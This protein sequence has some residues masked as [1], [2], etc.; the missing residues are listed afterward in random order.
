MLYIENKTLKTKAKANYIIKEKLKASNLKFI[1]LA[2]ITT[3]IHTT[4]NLLISQVF[5]GINLLKKVYILIINNKFNKNV[6]EFYKRY[7][8]VIK[9]IIKKS[10]NKVNYTL[11][12]YFKFI[13]LF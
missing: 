2:K 10:Q 3:L 11:Y 13:I 4:I 1:L 8:I 7:L 9:S 5:K 6:R 12:I